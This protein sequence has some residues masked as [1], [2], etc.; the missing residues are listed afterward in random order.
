MTRIRLRA[1]E[2]MATRVHEVLRGAGYM[3]DAASVD[4]VGPGENDFELFEAP[5]QESAVYTRVR[6]YVQGRHAPLIVVCATTDL[7]SGLGL[8]EAGA[9]DLLAAGFS[10]GELLA[11][12]HR[13]AQRT[14]HTSVTLTGGPITLDVLHRRVHVHG[15][16]VSLTKIE[17]DLLSFFLMHPDEALTRE[18][19]LREVWGYKTGATTTVTVHVRRLREKLEDD[20]A[21][22]MLLR[23]VWGVGYRFSPTP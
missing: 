19:L 1:S 8:Y 15:H 13:A 10:S 12:V 11:R 14:A 17:F 9:D 3:V 16:P 5:P 7:A 4:D 6:A 21:Q 2:P 18:R 20:P 22:P 23:T